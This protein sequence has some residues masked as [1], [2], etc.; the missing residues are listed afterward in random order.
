VAVKVEDI[1]AEP[2]DGLDF[3][4]PEGI[5]KTL[6]VILDSVHFKGATVMLL[7]YGDGEVR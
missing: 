1:V 2:V 4:Q 6:P 5:N 3:V 7:A